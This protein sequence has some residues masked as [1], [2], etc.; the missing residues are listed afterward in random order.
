MQ[1]CQ[2]NTATCYNRHPDIFTQAKNLLKTRKATP[3]VLSFGCSSGE[4]VRT[5]K[6]E[7]PSWE[8][9]GADV[10]VEY[11]HR[12]QK[13]DPK[14][15]YVSDARELEPASY[16]AIFCMSVL[17]RFQSP[18]SE[19]PFHAFL[20]ALQV[21]ATLLKPGGLLVLYNAQYDLRQSPEMLKYFTAQH[22][23]V[24]GGS[25]FVT[26]FSPDGLR[27]LPAEEAM[28]VPYLFWRR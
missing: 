28:S 6:T 9:H 10:N 13:A 22:S 23:L 3:R 26:K 21:L 27:K 1:R 12:A 17:C 24:L 19:F 16:D 5:L 18:A 8:V 15:Y 2:I 14:G 11:L 25:G 4:E 20:E 7:N